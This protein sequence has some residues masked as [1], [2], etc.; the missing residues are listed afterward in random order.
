MGRLIFVKTP[1]KNEFLK[2][3]IKNQP[4]PFYKIMSKIKSI[5]KNLKFMQ[6]KFKS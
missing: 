6:N 2:Q 4:I 5:I 3:R 1:K